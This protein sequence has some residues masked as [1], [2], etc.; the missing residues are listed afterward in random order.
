MF[1]PSFPGAALNAESA[2]PLYLQLAQR[3]AQAISDGIFTAGQKI[4]AEAEL[5]EHFGVSRVTVRQAVQ[6]L[7]R[8]GQV[9]SK[10]GKGTFVT[11]TTVRQDL[12][13]LQG[14]HDA[15]RSQGV[16]PETELLEFSASAGRVDEQMPAGLNLPVRLR[17]RYC[18]DGEPF[19]IVEGFLPPGA[20]ALGLARAQ[21]LTVYDIVQQYLGLHIGRADVAI[22]CVQPKKRILAEL[23]LA[24]RSQVLLMQ[25]TSYTV[26]GDPCEHMRIFIVPDRYTFHMSVAGPLQL[27]NGVKRTSEATR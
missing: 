16:E 26:A 13:N 5:M 24:A 10:R 7:S 23:G 25:R 22:Q 3:L 8:N 18:I 2:D 11:R 9:E 15:L 1:N 19:A 12:D 20:K 21:H 27:A 6:R 4:P 17:R 14:F